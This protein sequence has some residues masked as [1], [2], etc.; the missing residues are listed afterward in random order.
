MYKRDFAVLLI[1]A[2]SIYFSLQNEGELA[3]RKAWYKSLIMLCFHV[4]P[5]DPKC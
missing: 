2:L 1:A 4:S 5:G 3:F